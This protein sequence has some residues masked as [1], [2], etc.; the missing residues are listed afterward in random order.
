MRKSVKNRIFK[1]VTIIVVVTVI[2]MALYIM[3]NRLDLSKDMISVAEHIIMWIYRISKRS[4]HMMRSRQSFLYG[5]M[6]SCFSSG[7]GLCGS[8]GFGLTGNNHIFV[9]QA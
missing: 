9:I 2:I 3:A 7:D 8:Y 1:T 5:Y 6:L 4:F